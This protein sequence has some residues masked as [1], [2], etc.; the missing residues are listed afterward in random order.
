MAQAHSPNSQAQQYPGPCQ[1][2]L[3]SLADWVSPAEFSQLHSGSRPAP[4]PSTEPISPALHRR[5]PERYSGP[6]R[7]ELRGLGL[8]MDRPVSRHPSPHFAESHPAT[9]IRALESELWV[10]ENSAEACR[11]SLEWPSAPSD[12]PGSG[13][14]DPFLDQLDEIEAA[15]QKRPRE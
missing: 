8:N 15:L 1:A 4:A 3:G 12:G 14:S 2:E 6:T 9:S 13:V 5:R 7:E 10:T 11:S